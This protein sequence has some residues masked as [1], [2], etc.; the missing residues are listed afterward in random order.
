MTQSAPTHSDSRIDPRGTRF[1]AAVAAVLFLIALLVGPSWGLLPLI[2]QVFV[3]GSGAILGLR[4][5]P[6]GWYFRRFVRPS[7]AEPKQL[8]PQE[9]HRWAHVVH[10]ADRSLAPAVGK[11][12]VEQHHIRLR[13]DDE[14]YGQY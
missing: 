3:F 9:P 5:Q 2:V 4:F 7:L 14:R 11:V 12:D 10:R 1:A 8:V 13:F 6:Y